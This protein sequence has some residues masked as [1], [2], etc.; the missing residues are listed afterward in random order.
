M[1][2][3]IGA[4]SA[5]FTGVAN[6]AVEPTNIISD[7]GSV[8]Q[9]FCTALNW[10]FWFVMGLS[11]IMVLISAYMYA[12]SNGNEE[13]VH[14]ATRTLTYVSIAIVVALFAKGI[15]LIIG[16]FFIA[17]SNITACP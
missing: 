7:S 17:G 8:V 10:V 11:V 9:L 13:Q 14:N 15:P 6:G 1:G 5:A 16:N 12:T 3:V 2:A 4:I